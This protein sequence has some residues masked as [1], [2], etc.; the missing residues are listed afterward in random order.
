MSENKTLHRSTA[1]QVWGGLVILSA[2]LPALIAWETLDAYGGMGI[3]GVVDSS[4][5][6]EEARQ[7]T[8]AADREMR[9]DFVGRLVLF[10]AAAAALLA[11]GAVFIVLGNS[12]A[13]HGITLFNAVLALAYGGFLIAGLATGRVNLVWLLAGLH[14]LLFVAALVLIR[15]RN[16]QTAGKVM[17]VS[18]VTG[19]GLIVFPILLG[20]RLRS[21]SGSLKGP[22]C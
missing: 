9:A 16:L 20:L 5:S 14:C 12:R 7:A 3:A 21:S 2:F 13:I 6:E 18:G 17:I 22:D 10:V 4:L 19:A 1:L 11:L 8:E 15:G